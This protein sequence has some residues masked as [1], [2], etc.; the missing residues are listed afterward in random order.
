M[1]YTNVC[2]AVQ[3]TDSKDI[4][5]AIKPPL[6]HCLSVTLDQ[7]YSDK[8]DN[9]GL[10]SE[11]AMRFPLRAKYQFQIRL[12]LEVKLLFTRKK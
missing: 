4:S 11:M 3:T 6:H 9:E 10:K 1:C 7:V 8:S 12:C 2:S 5:K